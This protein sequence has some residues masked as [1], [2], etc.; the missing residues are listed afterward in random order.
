MTPDPKRKVTLED[1]LRLKRAEQPSP[2]F[3]T[4]FE[5]ELR[6]KQLAAIVAKRP[7]WV[8]YAR[9][10]GAVARHPLPLGAAAALAVSFAGYQ[11]YVRVATRWHAPQADSVQL[12]QAEQA[13]PLAAD[14]AEASPEV[15][16]PSAPVRN[17]GAVLVADRSSVSPAAAQASARQA[18]SF[19]GW[20]DR[21]DSPSARSIAVNLAAAQA[22]NPQILRNFLSLSQS[23]DSGLVP[24][25]R[26]VSEPLARMASPASERRSRLLADALPA[27]A[28]S[29]DGS[30]PSSEHFVSQISDERLYQSISRYAA[31]DGGKLAIKV[32]F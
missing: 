3:W 26:S 2:E 1:L 6:A 5:S 4:R 10:F 18:P 32:K 21:A 16:A 11:G 31:G 25:R 7:W 28:T 23:L 15:A 8:P 17:S 14:S 29:S 27:V 20:L 19:A 12:A 9:A 13:E 24:E 30:M 22:N